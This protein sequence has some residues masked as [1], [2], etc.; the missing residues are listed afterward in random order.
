M[1]RGR[2]PATL[3]IGVVAVD[4]KSCYVVYVATITAL[5]VQILDGVAIGRIEHGATHLDGMTVTIEHTLE[6]RYGSIC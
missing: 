1:D 2:Y 3:D 4:H 6:A 5:D